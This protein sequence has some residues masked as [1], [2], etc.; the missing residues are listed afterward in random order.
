MV[1]ADQ[2]LGA[3]DAAIG[4]VDLGLQVQLELVLTGRLMQAAENLEAPRILLFGAG[5]IGGNPVRRL[6]VD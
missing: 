1:P 6:P 4:D 5:L 2:R 3:A